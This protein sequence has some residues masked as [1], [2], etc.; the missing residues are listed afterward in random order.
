MN[1]KRIIKKVLDEQVWALNQTPDTELPSDVKPAKFTPTQTKKDP[2]ETTKTIER[3]E[4]GWTKPDQDIIDWSKEKLAAYKY[5]RH[6][7]FINS[8]P[9]TSIGK[10]DRKKIKEMEKEKN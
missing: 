1:L 7:E 6:V 2:K 4:I 9:R 5:P 8:L 3:V 10:P